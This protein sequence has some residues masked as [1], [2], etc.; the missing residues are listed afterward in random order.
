VNP[1]AFKGPALLKLAA[2]DADGLHIP[3]FKGGKE[4]SV[5]VD[6]GGNIETTQKGYSG[7]L[8]QTELYSFFVEFELFCQNKNLKGAQLSASIKYKNTGALLLEVPVAVG[9]GGYQVSWVL[10]KSSPAGDYQ[11]D[12]Y[13]QVDRR[14]NATAAEPFISITH[15]HVPPEAQPFPVRTEFLV[16]LLFVG[17]FVLTSWRKNEIIGSRKSAR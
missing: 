3:L 4:W 14:R 8:G 15:H 6:I 10:S 11:I 13:R 12:V 7:L 1:N 5:N 2:Q 9:S 17:T 16:L